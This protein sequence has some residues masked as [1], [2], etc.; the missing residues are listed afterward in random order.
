[1][2]N[3]FF[4]SLRVMLINSPL[5][6]GTQGKI[7]ALTYS[8]TPV[9]LWLIVGLALCSIELAVPTAFVAFMMGLSAIAIAVL[10][11]VIPS[12]KVQMFAWLMLSTASIVLSRRWLTPKR[13]KS[14]LKDDH[15]G[16]T[17]TEIPAGEVGRVFYEGNSWRAICGDEKTAIAANQPVYIVKQKGTTLIV[18][19][20]DISY[21]SSDH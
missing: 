2:I 6:G 13:R 15:E 1:M 18:L 5:I 7:L 19:P 11:L 4:F 12:I 14:Y 8:F 3:H 21:L 10:A 20:K 16:K 17:I 9:H